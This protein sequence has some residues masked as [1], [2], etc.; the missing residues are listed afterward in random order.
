MR[1]HIHKTF[2]VLEENMED[3]ITQVSNCSSIELESVS[4]Y[5]AFEVMVK[6][7]GCDEWTEGQYLTR[8]DQIQTPQ[9]AIELGKIENFKQSKNV[10][11]LLV[12]TKDLE[13][14]A[15]KFT[16][17]HDKDIFYQRAIQVRNN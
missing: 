2:A 3:S 12:Q 15:L 11:I 10:C 9:V 4:S 14:F 1:L 7:D 13:Y 6:Q 5:E 16:S 8:T 17:E